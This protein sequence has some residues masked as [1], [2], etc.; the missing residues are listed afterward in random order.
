MIAVVGALSHFVYEWTD[1]ASWATVFFSTNESA[2][3]HFKIMLWPIVVWWI[4]LYL[5]FDVDK[6]CERVATSLVFSTL[7]LLILHFFISEVLKVEQLWLH[8]TIFAISI[9]VGQYLGY[10]MPIVQRH[11]ALLVYTLFIIGLCTFTSLPPKVPFLF[12]DH[13]HGDY[14]PL[15]LVRR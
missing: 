9:G 5:A 7:V 12:Q 11:L 10:Y 1:C 4:G 15:C 14:G 6:W 8:I 2:W 13:R 3:E